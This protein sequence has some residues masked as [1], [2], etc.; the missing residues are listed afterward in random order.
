M[1]QGYLKCHHSHDCISIFLALDFVDGFMLVNPLLYC[2][3]NSLQLFVRVWVG[4]LCARTQNYCWN[5]SRC[6]VRDAMARMGS[7]FG[8]GSDSR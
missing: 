7:C 6:G 1:F 2:I 5:F 3:A 8:A 4:E